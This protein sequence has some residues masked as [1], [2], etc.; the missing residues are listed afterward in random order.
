MVLIGP[1]PMA[2]FE[3]HLIYL[4]GVGYGRGDF[5]VLP[6]ILTLTNFRVLCIY[7]RE[8]QYSPCRDLPP[9]RTHLRPIVLPGGHHFDGNY[10]GLAE[11]VLEELGR[12]H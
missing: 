10:R 1:E 9:G 3:F 11:V 4:L 2:S 5:P 7:G 6:E 12:K 8:E